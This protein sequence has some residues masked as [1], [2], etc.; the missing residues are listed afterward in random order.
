MN[1]E[2]SA[3]CLRMT[4]SPVLL[5]SELRIGIDLGG[6]K[7]EAAV[8]RSD[9]SGQ[10]EVLLRTRVPTMRAGGYEHVLQST[11]ALI[12]DSAQQAGCDPLKV[13]IGVG[14]PGSVRR[15]DGAVKNSNTT[16]LNGRPF[17]ADLQSAL[18]R[19]IEFD[20]DANCFA[21]AE[22]TLGA[23]APWSKGLVFGV[24]MGSGVGGAVVVD[25]RV[26]RGPH[27]IAGEWGHHRVYATPLR[28]VGAKADEADL[29]SCYCGHR[30]C[31]EAYLSGPAAERHYQSLAGVA[32][33]LRE[34]SERRSS[35]P[36]AAQCLDQLLDAF[37][38]GL[39]NVINILDP[40]AVVCGGGVSNLDLLYSEGVER[41]RQFVF[42]DELL[43]PIV[44]HQLGDSA[45][46]LGAALLGA[47]VSGRG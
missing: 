19:P 10:I 3:I 23:A 45:G 34:I 39:A 26:W 4:Q 40:T 5:A 44:R 41:V 6:T 33:G 2:G 37:G 28:G 32:R 21:L 30:G 38:R 35:D 27:A 7:T 42:N 31:V 46:V 17:R 9:P 29:R 36:H 1:E 22:A 15:R 12:R 24:I 47:S 16:C 18:G 25:G 14:M 11:V 8:I 20:N 13:P 43:T